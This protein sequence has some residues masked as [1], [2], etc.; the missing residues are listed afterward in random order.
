MGGGRKRIHLIHVAGLVPDEVRPVVRI[1]GDGGSARIFDHRQCLSRAP[2]IGK[3]R[4]SQVDRF[5]PIEEK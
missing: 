2:V 3:C 4:R 5:D 1:E